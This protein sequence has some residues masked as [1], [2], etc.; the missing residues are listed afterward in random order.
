MCTLC[1]LTHKYHLNYLWGDLVREGPEWLFHRWGVWGPEK[2]SGYFF[3][4]RKVYRR[5]HLLTSWS[6]SQDDLFKCRSLML[7]STACV[8]PH[9]FDVIALFT[10]L[11]QRLMRNLWVFLEAPWLSA[12]S[13]L[14]WTQ[15]SVGQHWPSTQGCCCRKQIS[16]T[17]LALFSF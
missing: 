11:V 10:V 16:T 7:S 4:G 2:A 17:A 15:N 1:H 9:I 6:S 13:S 8:K 3:M 12:R 14:T 5:I